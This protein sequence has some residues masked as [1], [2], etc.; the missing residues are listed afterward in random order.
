MDA[1]FLGGD[2][3]SRRILVLGDDIDALL[4]PRSPT[5]AM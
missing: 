2:L 5:G 1:G 3:R 4:E